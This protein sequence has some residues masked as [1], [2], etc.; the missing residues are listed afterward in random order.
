M[1]KRPREKSLGT[2]N[3][4]RSNHEKVPLFSLNY[5]CIF[6]FSISWNTRGLMLSSAS[7]N[8]VNSIHPHYQFQ[9]LLLSTTWKH[10]LIFNLI[11]WNWTF[12][13][14][15]FYLRFNHHIDRII[16]LLL[17]YH[18]LTFL[19]LASFLTFHDGHCRWWRLY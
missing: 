13:S 10:I 16:Q 8:I 18:I 12:T 1:K 11:L 14:N 5:I 15:S 4:S 6:W 2:F 3:I 19:F 17:F 9:K 7:L